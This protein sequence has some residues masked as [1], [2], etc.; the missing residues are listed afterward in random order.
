MNSTNDN[1]VIKRLSDIIYPDPADTRTG[2]EVAVDVIKAAG[3]TF[4]DK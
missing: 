4:E 2:D 3:L 1:L